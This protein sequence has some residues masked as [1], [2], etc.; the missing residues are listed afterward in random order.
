[1]SK[2]ITHPQSKAYDEGW[3]AIF[4]KKKDFLD[5][6]VE[7]RTE[8]NPEFPEMVE[9][10][11]EERAVNELTTEAERLSMYPEPPAPAGHKRLPG[12]GL[13]GPRKPQ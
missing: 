12:G 13:R 1:M 2:I 8:K 7:E 5:E 11:I 4:G 10:A 6:V 9:K 3:D